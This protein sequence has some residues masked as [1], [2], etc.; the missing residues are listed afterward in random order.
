MFCKGGVLGSD[1]CVTLRV[2]E[3][4]LMG[5]GEGTLYARP[6]CSGA[7]KLHSYPAV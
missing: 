5:E 3:R 6:N 7:C 4:G 1:G 2:I